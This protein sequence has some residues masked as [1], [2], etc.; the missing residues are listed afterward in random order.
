VVL[1]PLVPFPTNGTLSPAS[2]STICGCGFRCAAQFQPGTRH[3]R[4]HHAE[5][6]AGEQERRCCFLLPT[7]GPG[8]RLTAALLSPPG[9]ANVSA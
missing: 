5:V 7:G 6:H 3:C 2:V 4:K 1:R 9:A 8:W